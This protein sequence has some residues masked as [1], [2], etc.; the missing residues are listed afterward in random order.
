MNPRVK[1]IYGAL[2]REDTELIPAIKPRMYKMRLI[3]GEYDFKKPI[4]FER[5]I[6]VCIVDTNISNKVISKLL[7]EFLER[8]NY[9]KEKERTKK[10]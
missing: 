10:R 2:K 8:D 6:K 7:D 9:G 3:Y 1:R 5:S 4:K